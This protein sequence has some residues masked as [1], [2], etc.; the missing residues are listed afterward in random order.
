MASDNNSGRHPF[1]SSIDPV[2]TLNDHDPTLFTT[3][4]LDQPL[5]ASVLGSPWPQSVQHSPATAPAPLTARAHSLEPQRPVGFHNQPMSGKES[6]RGMNAGLRTGSRSPLHR[7]FPYATIP[8]TGGINSSRRSGRG[9]PPTSAPQIVTN[10]EA[11]LR[12]FA[13][14]IYHNETSLV[15]G[16]LSCL[17]VVERDCSTL[18]RF[19][20]EGYGPL[21]GVRREVEMERLQRRNWNRTNVTELDEGLKEMPVSKDGVCVNPPGVPTTGMI[22]RASNHQEMDSLLDIYDLN[23]IPTMFLHE[24]KLMYLNF[25]GASVALMHRVLD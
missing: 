5:H 21:S 16:V 25:I 19:V 23:F 6:P 7:Q 20:K 22:V 18:R 12:K 17:D 14:S 10:R 8:K 13:P 11:E 15:L 24:K 4:F 2:L 1:F 9:P 3:D